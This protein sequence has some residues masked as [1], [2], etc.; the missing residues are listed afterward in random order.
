MTR[1]IRGFA[2]CVSSDYSIVFSK[3]YRKFILADQK[4]DRI[5]LILYYMYIYN[6]Y[7][8]RGVFQEEVIIQNPVICATNNY[9]SNL[10][11]YCLTRRLAI[12][13]VRV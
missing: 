1:R 12:L 4:S 11:S 9:I 6:K 8:G 5:Q 2:L 3:Q 10:S 7:H 13:M